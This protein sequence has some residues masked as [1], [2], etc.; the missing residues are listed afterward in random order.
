MG[1]KNKH[2]GQVSQLPAEL[3]VR[4]RL[5]LKEGRTQYALEMAKQAYKQE[6]N[7]ARKE[8][9]C[10]V[11]LARAQ[12]LRQEGRPRDAATVLDNILQLGIADG[13]AG[14]L[15]K[16]AEELAAVGNLQGAQQILAKLPSGAVGADVMARAVDAALGQ[17]KVGRQQLPEDLRPGFDLILQAFA[18]SEVGQDDQARET[19][20][21]IG[22]QSPFLEWKLLLR[23]LLAYYQN[24]DA[25][26]LDN[27]QRLNPERLPARLTA[28]LRYLI[29]PAF[30]KVQPKKVQAI[31]Q[32]QADSLEGAGL[33]PVL[34]Q[35]Q[36]TLGNPEQIPQAFHQ[37]SSLLPALQKEAPQ[38][39]PRLAS[40]FYWL[41]V[42]EGQPQDLQRY[43][44]LFGNPPDDPHFDR[45][46]AMVY[47]QMGELANA[48]KHWQQYEG[49]VAKQP[50]VWGHGSTAGH[51][52]NHVRALVWCRMGHNA[53][54][55]P[56][57]DNLADL[58]PFLRDHPDRPKPL[59]PGA[60]DC[61][62]QAMELAPDLL[63]SYQSLFQL[64][65]DDGRNEQAIAVGRRLLERFPN[66][67]PTLQV[68][69]DLFLHEQDYLAALQMFQQAL[70]ANPLDRTLRSRLGTAHLFQA[71][72]HAE[73]GQFDE[74][75]AGY[76]ASLN[77]DTNEDK[78]PILCKWAACEFKAGDPSRAE[79]LLQKA[80]TSGGPKG[81]VAF[82]MVIEASRLKLKPALKK[83]FDQEFKTTLAAPPRTETA[84]NLLETISVHH[85]AG[86]T[87]YGQKTHEKKVLAYL[88][89]VS[90]R[91]FSESQLERVCY[92]LEGLRNSKSLRQYAWL[93]QQC[94]SRNPHF[95]FLEAESYLLQGPERCQPWKVA[96]LLAQA[97][98]LA[99][100]LPPDNKQK[101]LL[102]TIQQRQQSV[103]AFQPGF[104]GILEDFL[105]QGFLDPFGDDDFD[106]DEYDDDDF[107]E[108][109]DAGGFFFLPPPLPPPKRK[110]KKKKRR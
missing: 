35:L 26:A 1:K 76:Q 53:A 10:Q 7:P 85:E 73:A 33:V 4:A 72:K 59:K 64:Y 2:H 40:C 14:F 102:E 82:N 50:A 68:L 74:A 5:A 63:E 42:H 106:D 67:V 28:S 81:A 32:R 9:V 69:G 38:L 96:P 30:R 36:K 20:Q 66:H 101:A 60:E 97:E 24:D 92:A 79:E 86:I 25:R 80:L 11:Y 107:D 16:L 55:V 77:L 98:E 78:A 93:G 51:H 46:Q 23:G 6:P 61:F 56:N 71:R 84:V 104:M 103:S 65:R 90:K 109:D 99:K 88:D 44:R 12:Q 18:Q 105:N 21:G 22:L 54:S 52:A 31:L 49:W 95:F 13:D 62:H 37:A 70:Q 100:A 29:D 110:K 83:R 108:E 89:Q 17:G 3:E 27:W 91:E 8:L 34:R 41:V 47:E 87:Y 19:L 45:L 57:L 48:H 43:H 75:R 94:F 15:A 39:V 58:P